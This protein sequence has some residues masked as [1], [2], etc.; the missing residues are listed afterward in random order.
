MKAPQNLVDAVNRIK[1]RVIL[2]LDTNVI[3]KFPWLDRLK[4]SASGPFLLV[5]PIL[6][7]GELMRL[8]KDKDE[9]TRKKA[10]HAF[11]ATGK[12]YKRGKPDTGIELGNDLWLITVSAPASA[13]FNVLEDEQARSDKG[14]VDAALLRMTAACTQD[15]LDVSTLFVT[16]ENDLRRI[17]DITDGLSACKLS[18]LRSSETF[19]NISREPGSSRLPDVD[20]AIAALLD[21]NNERQVRIAMTLEELRSEKRDE[22][23]ARGSGGLTYD[24]KRFP[25]RWTFPYKNLALY[26][27]STDEIPISSE[28][29]EMPF[30]NL[31]FMGS[32]EGIPK[33]VRRYVCS[34]LEYEHQSWVLQT[35]L[36]RILWMLQFNIGFAFLKGEPYGPH[37]ET[38][39]R[40]L[41]PEVAKRYD[42][43]S[44]EHDQHMR[45]LF[46]RSA[47]SVGD[48]YRSVI[49]LN[50]ELE[51][52]LGWETEY[53]LS[54]GPWDLETALIEFLDDALGTWAV[55]ETR[56][57]CYPY[58]I[59]WVE[60]D[61]RALTDTEDDPEE[62]S[63]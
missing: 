19:E 1:P 43:L 7:D 16:E 23:I 3:M 59:Q 15:F 63:E 52:I 44:D 38:H 28:Y 27:L 55:G 8:R 13:G 17:A 45:S 33:D 22:L 25:F 46:D 40:N 20:E 2:V 51:E 53:D 32:D 39:K 12:F 62:D 21:P 49:Q 56:E 35:P 31:D 4:I 24:G 36:T 30:E 9:R 18:E 26:N 10:L 41:S 29:A 11:N 6:V 58:R 5:V 48:V 54:S 42:E 34:M 50:E 37:A 57:R 61:D 14:K 47:K 60:E